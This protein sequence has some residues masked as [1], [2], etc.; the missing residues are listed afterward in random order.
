V[1]YYLRTVT[2][3]FAFT[4]AATAIVGTQEKPAAAPATPTPKAA[5]TI[6]PLKVL[7]VVSRYQGE[8]RVSSLPYTLSVNGIVDPGRNVG[9]H[10]N[11]RMGAQVP[12]MMTAVTNVPKDMPQGG[13]IQYKDIGTNID[14]NVLLLEDGRF[15]LDITIDDSS[16]YPDEQNTSAAKGS[17]TFRAFRASDSMVL[18]DGGTAQFTTAIDKVSGETVK[19]DV[20]L[21]V[22]K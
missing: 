7:V 11:L 3:G 6:T 18:K 10:A 19:V 2:L 1:T 15:R 22:V 9:G 17:P 8:K 16:V 13:P 12:V 21:T 20:T 4:V 14:C 5:A